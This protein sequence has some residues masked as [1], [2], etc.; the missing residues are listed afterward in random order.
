MPIKSLNTIQSAGSPIINREDESGKEYQ[1]LEK[2]MD[3]SGFYQYVF[4]S[5][6]PVTYSYTAVEAVFIPQKS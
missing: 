2:G 4:L 6:N 1:F 3:L 5:V